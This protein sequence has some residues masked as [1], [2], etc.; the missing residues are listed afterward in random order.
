VSRRVLFLSNFP[1]PYQM[2]FL[3]AV[4]AG[5]E[6]SLASYF[7]ADRDPARGWPGPAGAR[8]L[9]SPGASLLP[10]ELRVH[11]TLPLEIERARPEAAIICG[12]SYATFQAALALCAVA[13]IPALVWAETP[14]MAEGGTARR[15]LRRALIEPVR[16]M[17]RGVMAVGTRAAEV[18]RGVLGAGVPV[19]SFPY[20]CDLDRY[21]VI[22]RGARDRPFTF[23]FSGQLV[24]RKGVDVL[25]AAFARAA[26]RDPG[27]RLLVAGDGP[28]RGR[29]Q[30]QAHALRGGVEFLGFVGWDDLPGVYARADALVIPSRHDGWALVVNEAFGA[31]LPVIASDAVGAAIELVRPGETGEI[32]PAGEVEPLAEA[33]LRVQPQATRMGAAAREVARDRLLPSQAAARL[34]RIVEAAIGGERLP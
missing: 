5:G 25:L 34:A 20:V 10:P 11:P 21:L 2:E 32:V 4:E 14:R 23:L 8:V 13:R 1:V 26:E 31:G 28:D 27:V 17:A 7:L 9:P 33:L 30:A 6:L 19:T 3:R 16:R 29:L 12:Y 18:W 24:A 15:L 22:E